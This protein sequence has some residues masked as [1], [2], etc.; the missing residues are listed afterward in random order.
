MSLDDHDEPPVA[1][2]CGLFK[3]A[4]LDLQGPSGVTKICPVA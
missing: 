4:D 1:W 3:L 2:L